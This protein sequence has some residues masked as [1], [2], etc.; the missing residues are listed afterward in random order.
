MFLLKA[1]CLLVLKGGLG[2]MGEGYERRDGIVD[3]S[4]LLGYEI[5]VMKTC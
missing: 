2:F 3:H 1:Y 4:G 5:K